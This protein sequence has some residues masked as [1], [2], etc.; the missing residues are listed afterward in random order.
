[1]MNRKDVDVPKWLVDSQGN[2]RSQQV[3]RKT[4]RERVAQLPSGLASV[5]SD[6]RKLYRQAWLGA[7]LQES[8]RIQCVITSTYHKV[9]QKYLRVSQKVSQR[10]PICQHI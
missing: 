1:M 3:R 9:S 7:E 6:R 4:L 2:R 10:S 5:A 8:G